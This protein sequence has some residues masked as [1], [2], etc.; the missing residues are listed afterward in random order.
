MKKLTLLLLILLSLKSVCQDL[1][2]DSLKCSKFYFQGDVLF[3]ASSLVDRVFFSQ[4]FF[5][6]YNFTAGYMLNK[7]LDRNFKKSIELNF[8]YN[9]VFTGQS[10]EVFNYDFEKRALWSISPQYRI[11]F[12]KK[13]WNKGFFGTIG[14][15]MGQI[16][17]YSKGNLVYEKGNTWNLLGSLG[18]RLPF[19]HFFCDF[20]LGSGGYFTFSKYYYHQSASN[21]TSTEYY[22]YIQKY[23]PDSSLK[24]VKFINSSTIQYKYKYGGLMKGD[25]IPNL[26]INFGI[27]F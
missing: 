18:Y 23:F 7:S 19:K 25:L 11:L 5:H 24:D 2:H 9:D 16:K 27:S 8:S 6:A 4:H 20:I 10:E 21:M 3:P 14:V 26:G 22:E 15:G 17:N 13:N 12:N 1:N